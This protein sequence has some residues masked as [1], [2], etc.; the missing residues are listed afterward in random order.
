MYAVLCL[1]KLQASHGCHKLIC[2]MKLS[3]KQACRPPTKC[4]NQ[5][6]SSSS[7]VITVDFGLEMMTRFQVVTC[8]HISPPTQYRLKQQGPDLN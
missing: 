5:G 3:L 7:E 1:S 8:G 6:V 2:A 4:C